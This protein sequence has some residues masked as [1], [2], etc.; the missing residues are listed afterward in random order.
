MPPT[1]K[2]GPVLP[3]DSAI[4]GGGLL[5]SLRLNYSTGRLF[6]ARLFSARLDAVID[7][8]FLKVLLKAPSATRL[9]S[10]NLP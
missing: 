1:S 7:E 5:D 8:T 6:S 3:N 4:L 10:E 9:I 2:V